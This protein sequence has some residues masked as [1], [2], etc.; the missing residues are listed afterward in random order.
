MPHFFCP[1]AL[2]TPTTAL[3]CALA[4]GAAPLRAQETPARFTVVGD[5]HEVLDASSGLVWKRCVEGMQWDGSTCA[6]VPLAFAHGQALRH[7]RGQADASRLAWRV[8]ASGALRRLAEAAR[9]SPSGFRASFPA[10]PAGWYWS[11]SVSIDNAPVNPYNYGNVMR[12]ENAAT[13]NRLA[14]LHAWAVDFDS[15]EARGDMPKKELLTLRLVRPAA[16]P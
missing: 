9:R 6:G 12:G 10:A 15:G 3:V 1:Q 5:G 4:L 16:G 11:A 8:P 2:R 7:A 13:A 14:F